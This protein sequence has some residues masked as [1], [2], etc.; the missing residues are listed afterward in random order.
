MCK[1][2][3][4]FLLQ[5]VFC[6]TSIAP[7]SHPEPLNL[8]TCLYIDNAQILAAIDNGCA[9][10]ELIPDEM[11][12]DDEALDHICNGI[13]NNP[14]LADNEDLALVLI[15]RRNRMFWL[16]RRSRGGFMSWF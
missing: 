12:N 10:S 11:K 2:E 5:C 3:I 4:I 9:E 14:S 6:C 15:D 1:A 8:K 7:L 16:N 13:D